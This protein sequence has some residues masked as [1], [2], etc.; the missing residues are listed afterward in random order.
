MRWMV[1]ILHVISGIATVIL[2][3]YFLRE[4]FFIDAGQMLLSIFIGSALVAAFFHKTQ[5]RIFK[6]YFFGISALV[7]SYIGLW[8]VLGLLMMH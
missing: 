7:L 1:Y 5:K 4:D 3:L 2:Y 6:I 8:L